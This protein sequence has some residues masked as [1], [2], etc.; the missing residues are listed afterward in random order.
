MRLGLYPCVLGPG[1]KAALAYGLE[2]VDERHRHRFEFNNAYRAEF[3]RAGMV[4]SGISPDGKL[5]EIAELSDHPYMVGSQFHPEFLSRPMKPHP[6][7]VGLVRAAKA[8]SK[9][10]VDQ[11]T[12]D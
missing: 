4:F 6:L 9:H 5:I 3:E 8:R 7:F 1:T 10:Q 11:S 2:Q 12:S